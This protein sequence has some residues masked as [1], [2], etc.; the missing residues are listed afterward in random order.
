MVRSE[1][2]ITG[3]PLRKKPTTGRRNNLDFKR[4]PKDQQMKYTRMGHRLTVE[5]FGSPELLHTGQVDDIINKLWRESWLARAAAASED[6]SE[7]LA[8]TDEIR[9]VNPT[10]FQLTRQVTT[11]IW[12]LRGYLKDYVYGQGLSLY[13][14]DNEKNGL[15]TA[16]LVG[17]LVTDYNFLY[18]KGEVS[19]FRSNNAESKARCNWE[20]EVQ[21]SRYYFWSSPRLLQRHGQHAPCKN[22]EFRREKNEGSGSNLGSGLGVYGGRV[23]FRKVLIIK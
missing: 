13:G 6:D 4:L 5:Y 22:A 12:Q 2:T 10:V 14:L 8:G 19:P 15:K 21:A 9:W 1:E 23:P 3:I 16:H 20:R 17:T 11:K 18:P 7:A